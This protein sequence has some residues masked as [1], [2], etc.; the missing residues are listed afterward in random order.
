MTKLELINAIAFETSVEKQDVSRVIEG[1]LKVS[2]KTFIKGESIY[3]RGFG[4]FAIKERAQKIARNIS[5]NTTIVLPPQNVV[6]FK[7]AQAL[8][9]KVAN[10]KKK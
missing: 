6:T 1:M 5:K 3:L 7:P 9:E 4:T 2:K 10:A 8:K